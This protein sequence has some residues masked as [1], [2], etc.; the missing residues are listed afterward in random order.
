MAAGTIDGVRAQ[1]IWYYTRFLSDEHAAA[2]DKILAAA[3]PGLRADLLA[4]RAARLEMKLDPEAVRQ[5]K[6]QAR[7]EGRR[8]EARREASGNSC[9]AGRELATEDAMA[10]MAFISAEAAALSRAG[11]AGSLRELRALVFTDRTQGLDPWDRLAGQ[12]GGDEDGDE[13]GDGG[14]GPDDDDDEG[15]GPRPPAGPGTPV[16]GPAPLPALINLTV[17][18]GTLYGWS[19]AAGEA[20]TWGLTDPADTRNIIQA[21]SRHPRSRWCVTV[22]G[23]GGT[24]I[25]HGCAR[26]QHS[27]TPQPRQNSPGSRDGPATGDGTRRP[28]PGDPPGPDEHQAAQLG[29]LLRELNLTLRPIA[30]G[31]CDH[32]HREDRYTPSR[33]LKHLVR[34]RTATCS[35]PGC[36]AQAIHCDLDHTRAYPAGITCECELGP[37]C[38][39]HHR[40]KQAPGWR[41][42]QPEPGLMRWTTPAGRT[43]TTRPTVYDV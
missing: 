9:L 26:G 42:E 20:G 2:A 43:Y 34:A 27:W 10:S 41:L 25:A 32:R 6:E 38:R 37:A 8:V 13:N 30:S 22:T 4:R 36:G 31:T 17:S 40:C 14:A 1:V 7:K 18:A 16:G 3:A 35:A 11:M 39:R 21:A 23:P 12:P 28:Q 15:G 24:A 5:R 33:L 19:D 29:Q